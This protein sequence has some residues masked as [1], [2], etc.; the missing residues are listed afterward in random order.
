[1]FLRRFAIALTVV[2]AIMWG[3]PFLLPLNDGQV[4]PEMLAVDGGRFADVQGLRTYIVERG[5]Q[6]GVPVLFVHGLLGSTFTFRNNV[7]VLAQAGFRTIVFDRPGSGL[8]DKPLESSYSHPSHSDFIE[9]LL[10][11]LQ[12]QKAVLVGHSAGG[13]I[14]AHFAVW[15]PDR[16]SQLVIVDGAIIGQGGPPPFVGSIVAFAPFTRWAQVLLPAVF[17]RDRMAGIL[18]SFYAD[19]TIV[20]ED[21]VD[22]YW[23]AFQTKGWANGLIGL[24]RDSAANKLSEAQLGLV[25]TDTLLVWGE[26]DTWAPLTQGERL[27]ELLPRA[28]ISVIPQVGHQPMEEAPDAFNTILVDWLKRKST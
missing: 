3:L 16:I 14:T 18:R 26:L 10:D 11:V 5:P 6:D 22:G 7:E 4:D 13:N 21:V 25:D 2:L 15:H 24:T 12:I 23:R 20:T 17:T 8:S 27:Q 1:M 9:A 19:P 28:S